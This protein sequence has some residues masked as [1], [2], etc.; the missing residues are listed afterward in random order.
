MATKNI[1]PSLELI[2]KYT[3]L[4]ENEKFC[5]PEYQRAYSWSTEQCEKLWQDIEA[6]DGS[7]GQDHYFFGTIIIDCSQSNCLSLIDGQQRT[8]TFLLLLKALQL[9]IKLAL[10]EIEKQETFKFVN[11]RLSRSY[12]T[13]LR[14]LYKADPQKR[15]EIDEDWKKARNVVIFENNSINENYAKDFKIIIEAETFQDAENNVHKIPRKQKDNKYTNYFRNFKYF[16]KQIES[17]SKYSY[18]DQL[19]DFSDKF[20]TKCQI[21]KIICWD[22]EQAITMFNSLNSTGMPLTDAD[23]ISARLYSKAE[24]KEEFNEQWKRIIDLA[25]HKIFID[26]IDIQ[27]ILQQFMYIKRAEK[28]EYKGNE[29]RTP[30]IRSYYIDE[31]KDKTG[32]KSKLLDNPKQLCDAFEKI[33]RIWEQLVKLPIVKLL[34][35]FNVNFKLFF[36]SYLFCRYD[37][38]EQIEEA[39]IKPIVECFLRFFALLEIDEVGYS[40]AKFKTFLFSENLKLVDAEYRDDE[41]IRDFTE[42][43]K[44]NWKKEDVIEGLMNYE[45]NILVFLNEYIYTEQSR[46]RFDFDDKVN[47]EHIMPSSGRKNEFIRTDAGISDEEF[48]SYLNLLGNKILLEEN[49]NKSLGDDWF[50]VKIKAYKESKFGLPKEIVSLYGS[51]NDKWKK[52]NIESYTRKV[53]ERIADFIFGNL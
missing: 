45:K 19:C 29:V 52:E 7:Q 39:K 33:L 5:I 13:I 35:K 28:R 1:Q 49:L 14:I 30:G 50:R 24:N 18:Y 9:R 43:I 40:S 15:V 27:S 8:T 4:E 10:K 31:S 17:F 51:E 41:I 22:V 6:F 12:E 42:H 38:A 21:I 36:I 16:D 47:V 48:E 44:D 25:A 11:A 3:E 2:S 37:E 53:A 26:I 34:L 32:N 20:L 23:I 46:L